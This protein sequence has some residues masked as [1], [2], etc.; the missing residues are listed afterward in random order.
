MQKSLRAEK[1][2]LWLFYFS[3]WEQCKAINLFKDISEKNYP[4]L[5]VLSATQEYGMVCFICYAGIWYG[6]T[7]GYRKRYIS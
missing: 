4:Y 3:A 6:K 2:L 7:R 5:P 1:N